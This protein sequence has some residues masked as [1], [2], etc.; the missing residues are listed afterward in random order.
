MRALQ[1][2]FEPAKV[3]FN[4][5]ET[6]YRVDPIWAVGNESLAM[7]WYTRQG[8]GRALNL[9]FIEEFVGSPTLAGLCT[10]PDAL[11]EDISA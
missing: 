5:V 1:S 2:Y 9:W 3:T 6:D 8:D 10:N 11:E 4:V 7:K